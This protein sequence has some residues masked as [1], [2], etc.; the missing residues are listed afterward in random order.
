MCLRLTFCQIEHLSKCVVTYNL[1]HDIKTAYVMKDENLKKNRIEHV[2]HNWT[3][4]LLTRKDPVKLF[5]AA[6]QGLYCL[7]RH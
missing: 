3:P 5:N 6:L 7:W 2:S 4:A 1:L